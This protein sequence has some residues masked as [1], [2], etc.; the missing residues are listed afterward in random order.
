MALNEMTL[1]LSEDINKVTTLAV[2]TKQHV[3]IK[4]LIQK[5]KKKFN[6]EIKYNITHIFTDVKQEKL[7]KW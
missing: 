7:E 1:I 5:I 2:L 3:E 4:N 6:I